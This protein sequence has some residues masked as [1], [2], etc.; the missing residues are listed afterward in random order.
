MEKF[1]TFV[2]VVEKCCTTIKL[3]GRPLVINKPT[4]FEF[5]TNMDFKDL[6]DA[7]RMSLMSKLS[8]VLTVDDCVEKLVLSDSL[9]TAVD[10]LTDYEKWTVARF[11]AFSHVAIHTKEATVRMSILISNVK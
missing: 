10:K 2:V 7:S 4:E 9:K 5:E 8:R 6:N 11:A 3:D 1:V